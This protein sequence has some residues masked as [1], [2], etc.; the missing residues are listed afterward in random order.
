[1]DSPLILTGKNR[2]LKTVDNSQT[3]PA[4]IMLGGSL[5]LTVG[6]TFIVQNNRAGGAG[7]TLSLTSSG[8]QYINA[9]SAKNTVQ[10]AAPSGTTIAGV[11][12]IACDD[13]AG[14]NFYWRAILE[15]GASIP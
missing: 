12:L 5:D 14:G 11:T 2:L 6:L 3:R 10:L 13:G 1:M 9:I 8:S 15:S 4:L 7:A